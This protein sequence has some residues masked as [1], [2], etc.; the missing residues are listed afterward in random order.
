MRDPRCRDR[1]CEMRNTEYGTRETELGAILCVR[2]R[3]HDKYKRV[4]TEKSAYGRES[5]N[6]VDCGL[7]STM[8]K[9][10]ETEREWNA[11]G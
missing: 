1:G 3:V 9:E 5:R 4:G 7:D 11:W 2:M 6:R 10:T 8:A